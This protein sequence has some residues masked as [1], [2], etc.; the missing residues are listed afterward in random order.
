M[1][2]LKDVLHYYIG[3]HVTFGFKGRQRNG[4]LTGKVEPFGWQVLDLTSA[5]GIRHN[6]RDELIKPHLRPL[7]SMT[8]EEWIRCFKISR[9]LANDAILTD[10]TRF[11]SNSVY[12]QMGCY[13][14][15][16]FSF[17]VGFD[18]GDVRVQEGVTFYT[19]EYLAEDKLEIGFEG[20]KEVRKGFNNEKL[21]VSWNQTTI[22]NYLL[23]LGFDLFGLIESKQAIDKNTLK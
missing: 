19:K 15:F 4:L 21:A 23:S 14:Q 20:L 13:A 22:F 11:S 17:A 8:E 1:I 2:Q 5:F 12:I 6:V 9:G 7:S 16:I 10:I 18:K 3:C